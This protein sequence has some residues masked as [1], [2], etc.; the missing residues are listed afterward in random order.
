MNPLALTP[1]GTRVLTR[2]RDMLPIEEHLSKAPQEL[3]ES[4]LLILDE[5][6]KTGL[7]PSDIPPSTLERLEGESLILLDATKTQILG[8]Y[9]FRTSGTPHRMIIGDTIVGSMCAFDPLGTSHMIGQP[10]EIISTCAV[11]GRPVRI[12]V[13][14]LTVVSSFPDEIWICMDWAGACCE[15]PAYGICEEAVYI[16]GTS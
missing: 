3:R 6:I 2:L 8:A 5:Y 15:I 12:R 14:N 16:I 7:P 9:P 10:V 13:D 1:S 11:S 4:Y